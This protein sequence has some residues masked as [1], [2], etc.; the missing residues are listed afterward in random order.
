MRALIQ[1]VS[2]AKV[3]VE[4]QIIGEISNGLMVLLG[5]THEDAQTDID[6]LVKKIT[7]LRIFNDDNGKMNLSVTDLKG[8]ILVISQFTLFANSKKGN[9]PSYTRSAPP[10]ISIPLY[11]QF[12]ASLKNIF[13]GKVETGSF[14]AEM[15]VS[16]LNDGPVTI[17]LDSRQP[18]Y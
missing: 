3:E 2:F 11:E 10:D 14:G 7:Q 18:D 4:Q 17:M 13:E 12:V 1:R 5:V 6:W 8:E 9:R 16:L 15:K